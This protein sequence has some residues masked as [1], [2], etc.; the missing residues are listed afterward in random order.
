MVIRWKTEDMV[1]RWKTEDMVAWWKTL[2]YGN[3]VESFKIWFYGGKPY[4][5]VI[6]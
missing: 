2:R 3:I 4:D 6:W 5:M 1:L